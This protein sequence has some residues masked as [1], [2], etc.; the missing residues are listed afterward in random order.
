MIHPFAVSLSKDDVIPIRVSIYEYL[1][2]DARAV[3]LPRGFF[4]PRPESVF[5]KKKKRACFDTK[6][7][8]VLL[9]RC[10]VVILL[11]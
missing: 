11:R 4:A 8:Y 10:A 6:L 7:I 5:S 9:R 2:D 3:P 1:I